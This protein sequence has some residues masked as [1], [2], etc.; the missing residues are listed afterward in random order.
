MV[1]LRF[2]VHPRG[3][4]LA[5]QKKV[6]VRRSVHKESWEKIAP[7]I[8]NLKGETP[9]WQVC[10]DAFKRMVKDGTQDGYANCG[11]SPLITPALRKWLVTRLKALRKVTVCTSDTLQRELARV[12]RVVVEASTVRRHLNLAGYKW[13][14]RGKKRKYT[15]EQKIERKRFAEEVLAMTPAQLKAQLHFSMD[16]VVLTIPPKELVARENFIRTDDLYVWRT[17]SEKNLPELSG[18]DSY[19]KQVP[20]ARMLPLWGGV[21]SGGFGLVLQHENRKVTAEEW[22]AAVDKGNL[23]KALRTANPGRKRGPWKILCDNESFLRAAASKAAHQRCKVELWKLPAKS[24][25]LNPIE[26]YW[27]WLRKEMKAKDLEDL[28]A[29]RPAVAKMA[30]KARLLCLIKTQRSNEVAANIMLNLRKAAAEVKK[31]GGGASSY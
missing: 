28:V 5:Q 29:K 21:S 25:D 14:P 13:M 10:R 16:G 27:A 17:P 12:K 7:Q 6:Y 31:N 2:R 19:S 11:R 8:K 23:V 30:Y 24:P 15:K 18:H 9:G 20:K 3:L 22:A 1:L 4:S 26:K